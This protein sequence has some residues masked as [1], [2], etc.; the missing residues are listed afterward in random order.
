MADRVSS[1]TFVGRV[2]Q[3]RRLQ[4]ALERAA[5]GAPATVLV[6]GEAGVGKTRL[7]G[8]FSARAAAAGA[9]VL[10]GGCIQLGEGALPYAPIVEALRPLPRSLEPDELRRLAGPAPAE[11]GRLL[12]ELLGP[13][14]LPADAGVVVGTGQARLFELL[15]GLLERLGVQAPLVLVVEDLHW[16]DR[17][18]RDLLGFLARNL[19][20]ERVLLVATYRSDELHRQHPL[21]P[22]LAELDRS[23]R[24]RRLELERFGREELV[25]LLAGIRGAPPA[26]ELV[27]E[28]LA[29]SEGNPFFAEELLAADGGRGLP[30]GLRDILLVRVEALPAGAQ[31]VLRVAAAAGRRVGHQLLAMVAGLPDAELLDGLRQAVTHQILVPQP[32]HDAYAFRHALMQEAVYADL[33]PGERGR[34]HAAFARALSDNPELSVGPGPSAAAELAYHWY[35]A[36]ELPQALTA[37][38]QAGQAA[39]GAYGFAE[40]QRHF[41]RALEL[42][43]RVPEAAGR[44]GLDRLALL[45]LAAEAAYL[46]G[47]YGRA[48]ALVR[49]AM[50]EPAAATPFR[51]GMLYER[52]GRYLWQL[53]DDD[54]LAAYEQAVRLIPADPPSPELARVLA[55]LARMQLLRPRFAEARATAERAITIGRQVGAR[56]EEGHARN[57]LGSALAF[58]GQPDEGVSQLQQALRIAEAID[59][60]DDLA[61]AHVNLSDVLLGLGR[62]EEAVTVALEGAEATRRLGL[63]R[64]YIATLLGNAGAALFRLGRWDDADRLADQALAEYP[65]GLAAIWAH[66]LRADLDIGWGSFPAAQEHLATARRLSTQVV[67]GAQFNGPLFRSLAELCCWQGRPD[68]ALDAVTKALQLLAGTDA[69]RFVAPLVTLGLRALADRAQL[70]RDRRDDAQAAQTQT[71]AAPWLERARALTRPPLPGEPH[72]TPE[73]LAEAAA[74]QAEHARLAGSSDPALWSVAAA[75]WEQRGQPYPTAYARWRQ[76]EALVAGGDRRGAEPTLLEAY[77]AATRLRAGPLRQEI[78]L[79]ARRARLALESPT[80]APSRPAQPGSLGLGLTPREQEVLALVAAGRSNGQIAETLFISRKTASV[81][82]SNILTKLGA[83][84]RVEAAAIAHRLGITGHDAA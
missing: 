41:E 22:L 58:L 17:S 16:A 15:L 45:G 73:T 23:G 9:R 60:A 77:R 56:G 70:A 49:T 51:A 47:E 35:A 29:R 65:S 64:P 5:A 10:V 75:R 53:G 13:G 2:E 26:P 55:G 71:A 27:D 3:L 6:S 62:L 14:D 8:E 33:L 50:Q 12:P 40:A 38:V 39:M 63:G 54:A 25:A 36:H 28:I 21:R 11:L 69:V 43:D 44:T 37:A 24:V 52:L 80:A 20:Q 72:P 67:F 4:A 7:V 31:A 66:I 84:N 34:L 81:H 18:T 32:E 61:R 1:P 48:V 30:P 68:Q 59:G 78:E 46:T 79:L 76:A 42:W 82:V 57:T 74:S 83:A 19:R